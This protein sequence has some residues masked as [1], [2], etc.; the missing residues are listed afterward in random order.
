MSS[1]KTRG[2]LPKKR[3]GSRDVLIRKYEHPSATDMV[4]TALS[5][6]K[7]EFPKNEGGLHKK[8]G[9]SR[10]VHK[11][12]HGRYHPCYH[13]KKAALLRL[14]DPLP[15]HVDPICCALSGPGSIPD[16]FQKTVFSELFTESATGFLTYAAH[17]PAEF[18]VV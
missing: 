17:K 10:D 11:R 14:K 7:V 18:M 5:L 4:V 8:R 15:E 9:G 12:I 6:T 3:G 2:V 1:Q 16:R 13:P